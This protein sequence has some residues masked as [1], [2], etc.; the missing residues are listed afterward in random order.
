[1]SFDARSARQLSSGQHLTINAH[2]GLRLKVYDTRRTW[3]Y[4]YKSP[5][6][7][8]MRQVKLGQ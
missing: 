3:I 6:D 4:R 5:V 8:R 2:P 7:G 1:M